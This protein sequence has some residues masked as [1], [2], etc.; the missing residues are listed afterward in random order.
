M[1]DAEGP[2]RF[3]GSVLQ[4]FDCLDLRKRNK[5]GKATEKTDNQYALDDGF[6]G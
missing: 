2:D 3:V 1:G 4:H 6:H 5:G